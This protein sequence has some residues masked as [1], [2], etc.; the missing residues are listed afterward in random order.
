MSQFSDDAGSTS[1]DN[2][3]AYAFLPIWR[4]ISTQ[5]VLLSVVVLLFVSVGEFLQPQIS[6]DLNRTLAL[7]M[8]PLPVVLWLRLSVL[9]EYRVARPRRRLIGVAVVSGLTAAAIGLPL[10]KDFYRIEAWLPLES[11][12]QRIVGY[13][14]AVGAVDTG[15]R[16]LVLRYLV[17]SQSL[18]VRSDAIA[19]AL[20]G[21]V[22]YSAYLN[23]ALVW[24]LE[25][26]WDIAAIFV[27]TNFTAQLASSFFIALG[28]NES[29]FS[30][31][32]PLVL[33]F[34]VLLAAL[35][36]GFIGPLVGGIMSGPLGLAGSADRPLYGTLLLLVI[37]T[38]TLAVVYFLYSNAER[39]EREAFA[40]RGASDG[41]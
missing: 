1:A 20:A 16:F 41:I 8:V 31:A 37:L 10:V 21:A 38:V 34:N 18:R 7:V 4:R 39:R 5:L 36:I 17:Y 28:F 29:Y 12:V 30:D 15:L 27:L 24:Q 13:T 19:Y 11:V 23:L 32:F 26:R 40:G 6:A 14:L 2:A 33:P 22:G 35:A 3:D 25:P 9:P